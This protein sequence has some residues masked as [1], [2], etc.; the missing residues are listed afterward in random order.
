MSVNTK[1][2]KSTCY[3]EKFCESERFT[4]AHCI[5]IVT[6]GSTLSVSHKHPLMLYETLAQLVLLTGKRGIQSILS[7]KTFFHIFLCLSPVYF[8]CSLLTPFQ[9]FLQQNCFKLDKKKLKTLRY[10]RGRISTGTA[11][12]FCSID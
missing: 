9:L 3:K 11:S 2:F 5:I 12:I 6:L 7:E 10:D 1:N 4:P 8:L